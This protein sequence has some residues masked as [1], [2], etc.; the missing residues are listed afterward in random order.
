MTNSNATSPSNASEETVR[1]YDTITDFN[2]VKWAY[3]AYESDT[4]HQAY[5]VKLEKGLY[6]KTIRLVKDIISIYP[7][8]IIVDTPNEQGHF[9]ILIDGVKQDAITYLDI[10]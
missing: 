10:K 2:Y 8:C 1:V 7:N 4:R 3:K 9:D 5:C 6:F